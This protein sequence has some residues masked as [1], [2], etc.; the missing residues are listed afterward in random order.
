MFSIFFV[1]VMVL[2][3][4]KE[5]EDEPSICG[6]NLAN[7]AGVLALN[8][9]NI[10]SSSSKLCLS[11]G[12]VSPIFIFSAICISKL[13][14]VTSA[15]STIMSS[16]DCIKSCSAREVLDACIL[17]IIDWGGVA[18]GSCPLSSVG[19]N[20]ATPAPMLLIMRLSLS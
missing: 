15:F 3:F 11:E 2:E 5:D 20:P 9:P 19:V 8:H 7:M 6:H 13:Y 18:I 12:I 14:P 4:D 10:L 1:V 16:T 17:S